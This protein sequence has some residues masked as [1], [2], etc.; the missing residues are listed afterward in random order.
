MAKKVTVYV[1]DEHVL[2][3]ANEYYR[4]KKKSFVFFYSRT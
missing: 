2:E 3:T 4:D 1:Y